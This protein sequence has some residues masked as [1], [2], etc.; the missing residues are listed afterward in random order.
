MWKKRSFIIVLL[1]LPTVLAACGKRRMNIQYIYYNRN[2]F[3]NHCIQ[4]CK[5]FISS[6]LE[7]ES[8]AGT[9]DINSRPSLSSSA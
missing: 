1:K 4:C 9:T 5:Y 6:I 7:E 8:S 2:I 3:L